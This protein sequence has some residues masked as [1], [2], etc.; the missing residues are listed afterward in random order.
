MADSSSVTIRPFNPTGNVANVGL[1]W[2][3]WVEELILFFGAKDVTKP[4]V[5]CNQLLYYGGERVQQVWKT[6]PESTT[7][8][9]VN[10]HGQAQQVNERPPTSEEAALSTSIS[11]LRVEVE[12]AALRVAAAAP[13]DIDPAT[14]LQAAAQQAL[15]KARNCLLAVRTAVTSQRTSR[16]DAN[17]PKDEF[18]YMLFSLNRV[19]VGQTSNTYNRFLFNKMRPEAGE[20]SSQFLVKLKG[21]IKSCNF[22]DQEQTLVDMIISHTTNNELRRELLKKG[23]ELNFDAA[24]AIA[25]T[26]EAT[27]SQARAME[28]S[29]TNENIAKVFANVKKGTCHRCGK[30]DHYAND[31]VCKARNKT[32]SRC[33]KIGH[34]AEVCRSSG[35]YLTTKYPMAAKNKQPAPKKGNKFAYKKGR[36]HKVEDED[37][38]NIQSSSS[39]DFAFSIDGCFTNDTE[40]SIKVNVGGVDLQFEI[41]SCSSTNIISSST[42]EYCKRRGI[43][44]KSTKISKDLYPYN[45][46]TPLK[47]LGKFECELKVGH[48]TTFD[49]VYV[50]QGNDKSLLSERTS[51]ALRVLKVGLHVQR[52]SIRAVTK[53]TENQYSDAAT[54]NTRRATSTEQHSRAMHPQPVASTTD[55]KRINTATKNTNTTENKGDLK[56]K[57]EIKQEFP[58]V[59]TGMGKLKDYELELVIDPNMAPALQPL[60]PVPLQQQPKVEKKIEELLNCD[61]LEPVNYPSKFCSP[62]HVAIKPDDDIRFCVDMRVANLCVQRLNH[63][64][65]RFEEVCSNLKGS[66]VFS[67][68]DMKNAYFQIQLSEASREI[69]TFSTH[70]GLFRYKRLFCGINCAPETFQK[71]MEVATK[72]CEGLEVYIDDFLIHGATREI[73]DKRLRHFLKKFKQLGLT[74]NYEKCVFATKQVHFRGHCFSAD[75]VKPIYSRVKAMQEL[76]QPTTPELTA[77]L[78]GL[79]TYSGRFIPN[80]SAITKPLRDAANCKAKDFKWTSEQEKAFQLLKKRVTSTPVLGYFDPELPTY[81]VSDASPFALGAV[82]FQTQNDRPVIIEYASRSL[83]EV[84]SRYSQ[85]EK[86]ALGL[87]WSCERFHFWLYGGKKFFLI[88][89]HKPLEFI[90]SIRAKP[91]ARIERWV[92]RLQCYNYQVLYQAG[93]SN[94]ADPLSR[95]LPNKAATPSTGEEDLYVRSVVDAAMPIALSFNEIRQASITDS[96]T[97]MLATAINT[98]TWPVELRKYELIKTE[99]CVYDD[100]ILRGHRLYIPGKMRQRIL[101]LAHE[102]HQGIVKTKQ[103]LRSKVWWFTMDK[104]VEEFCKHCHGCQIVAPFEH[105]EPLQPTALPTGA[106]KDIAIDYLGPFNNGKNI[107]VVVDYYSR[108]IEAVFTTSTTATTTINIL[109]E[110]F[111]RF[112]YPE[113]LRADQAPQFAGSEMRDYC[114]ANGIRLVSTTPR[115]PQANGEVERQNRSIMK[116]LKIAN[117]EKIDLQSALNS[118]LLAYRST[119]HS[120]TGVSPAKLMFNREIRDKLPNL[121]V[122]SNID[123]KLIDRDAEHKAS[124]K[125]YTDRTRR[126]F[127]KQLEVGDDVLVRQQIQNK[128]DTQYCPI[129]FQVT[130]KDGNAITVRAPSGTEYRRNST[131][132]KPYQPPLHETDTE[133]N[134]LEENHQDISSPVVT[135]SPVRARAQELQQK[136]TLANTPL[137]RSTRERH[138]PKRFID[139]C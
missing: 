44:C 2:T 129:P 61:I 89:D 25:R 73:H 99:L 37:L 104:D 20:T 36:I 107:L 8:F 106:W 23:D 19:F 42:W 9:D 47:T 128:L 67:K 124:S 1:A 55:R 5:K 103:R 66:T 137:R 53:A 75:G 119:P 46:T 7:P 43:K 51:K 88:T 92:L 108:F 125:A 31:P 56:L 64:I 139:E 97:K 102:G 131:W 15:D 96:Y 118:Y 94:I 74:L 38:N 138:A 135:Q 85:T 54:P 50:V 22:A 26:V 86:E 12:Q 21:K 49:E 32:C 101:K 72:D 45:S 62:L 116:A 65:P 117:A 83:T 71:I 18:E 113:S 130:A 76:Q 6:L 122:Q 63:P 91:C 11:A 57:K 127:N 115:H 109:E 28:C 39:A 126:A 10:I 48:F 114:F 59:F 16:I 110:I 70:K 77:S 81:V 121:S 40:K 17:P 24:L 87:V 105:P 35:S 52:E 3:Q 93:K 98:D 29:N 95:L 111:C 132:A 120:I 4:M 123:Q 82:L 79:F 13:E 78:L 90:F 27:E 136:E 14:S 60:R 69:T 133:L 68:L 80:F 34:F 134:T 41:D 58:E 84:E 112:G 33:Q 100:V 30:L